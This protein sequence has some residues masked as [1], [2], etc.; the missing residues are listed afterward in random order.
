MIQIQ[1]LLKGFPFFFFFFE[2]PQWNEGETGLFEGVYMVMLPVILP[3]IHPVQWTNLLRTSR[4][5]TIVLVQRPPIVANYRKSS[6]SVGNFGTIADH[7]QNVC[8]GAKQG[9]KARHT[10]GPMPTQSPWEA[11]GNEWTNAWMKPTKT[12]RLW[13]PQH[14]PHFKWIGRLVGA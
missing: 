5:S 9:T 12:R 3:S 8:I 10:C 13:A 1:K 2:N 11:I 14:R 6:P 7:R 4:E